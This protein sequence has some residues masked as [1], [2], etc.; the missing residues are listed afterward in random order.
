MPT[1]TKDRASRPH[2][3]MGSAMAHGPNEAAAKDVSC[4]CAFGGW[5]RLAR[6]YDILSKDGFT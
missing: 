3:R 4:P 5:L 1:T 2:D 6:V